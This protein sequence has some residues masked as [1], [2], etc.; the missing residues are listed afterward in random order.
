MQR[1]DGPTTTIT[2][3]TITT[4][5]PEYGHQ[6]TAPLARRNPLRDHEVGGAHTN[7]YSRSILTLARRHVGAVAHRIASHRSAL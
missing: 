5:T 2:T 3:T 6:G 7:T 1:R 4:T